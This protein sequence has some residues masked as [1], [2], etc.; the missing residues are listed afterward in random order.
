L[1]LASSAL[2]RDLYQ[3]VWRPNA[4]SRQVALLGLWATLVLGLVASWIALQRPG[5]IFSLVLFAS[6]G[7]GV[8]FGPPVIF[9][10]WGKGVTRAAILAGMI[11]G[12][13]TTALWVSV[14][15][16]YFYG[17]YEVI[18][19]VLVGVTL[20]AGVSAASRRRGIEARKETTVS[21]KS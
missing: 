20:I 18:P 13:C 2:I 7:L 10:L 1:S 15:K 17:L 19:G 8:A 6:G 11:G 16:D 3:Q 14:F 4:S 21:I 9:A 5:Q 12:F